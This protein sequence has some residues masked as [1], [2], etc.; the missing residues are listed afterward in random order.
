PL[1]LAAQEGHEEV[2][3]IL[4]ANRANVNVN[5]K[6]TPLHIAAA[7]G[8]INVI[9]VLLSNGAKVNVKDN[10]S[11]TP[12]ELAVAHGHLQVVKMLLQYKKVDMNAKGND[13]WTILHIAS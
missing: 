13:D 1:Y 11:R 12:L 9:E 7:Q 5:V 8:H 3:E 4:I 6:G 10:K 2:A